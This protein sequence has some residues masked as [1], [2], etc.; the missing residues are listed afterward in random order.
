MSSDLDT[1]CSECGAPLKATL[2]KGRPRKTCR[3]VCELKRRVRFNQAKAEKRREA[4]LY[5]DVA[6]YLW[7]H[8][9]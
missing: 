8:L 1:V 7:G 5:G 4:R 3:G 9:L 2:S 6:S